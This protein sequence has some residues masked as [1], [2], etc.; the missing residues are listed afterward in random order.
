MKRIKVLIADDHAIVRLGIVELLRGQPHIEI[1]G[2][3]VDGREAVAN[4]LALRPDVIV[5]DI[6][7]PVLSGLEAA[8]EIREVA[9]ETRVLILTVHDQD[10]YL[11]EALQAGAAGYVLKGADT[12]DLVRAIGVVHEGEIF[13]YPRMTATL[14][15]EYLRNVHAG[16]VDEQY[17]TL[18]AREREVLELIADG[19]S[20]ADAAETL[21]LSPHTVQ[22]HREHIMQ[23][24]GIHSRTELLKYAVRKG[25]IQLDD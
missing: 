14:V 20:N 18:T 10:E 25:L 2:E 9:P 1:V 6:S 24:L 21:H 15:G 4:T 7:M 5:M 16:E 8:A 22:T 13:I 17:E 11:F 12:E 3:A 19:R 23:K